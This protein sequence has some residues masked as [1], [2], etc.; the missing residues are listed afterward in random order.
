V[1][2]DGRHAELP[3]ASQVGRRV[4]ELEALQS[5]LTG[6]YAVDRI[7]GE[8]GMATVYLAEDIKH[9]RKVAIKVLRPE[10]SVALGSQRFQREIEIAA[11]LS[12]P[13]IHPLHDSGEAAGLLYYVMP[14]V[15][16][17]SL[18]DR[19]QRDKHLP[20][21]DALEIGCQ[22]AEALNYAHTEGVVHRDVKPENILL[23]RGHVL[24]TDFGIAR[25]A[26]AVGDAAPLTQTGLAVGTP[27]YMSP[28]Q[29]GGQR[30]VDA[31]CDV[32][33]L[34]CVLYE[35]LAG[36]PPFTGPTVESVLRQHL[37]LEAPPIT[38]LRP[39]V[40]SGIT[41]VLVRA[42]AKVPADRFPSAAAF[43]AAL[44]GAH[45][46]GSQRHAHGDKLMLAVGCA[47]GGLEA[48]N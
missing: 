14:Y 41:K 40:P 12:H 1:H 29:A 39:A 30:D 34:G 25:V 8:G 23:S 6:R 17:E 4:P 48:R 38:A 16:G 21:S 11:R 43:M 28:E 31:R 9:R 2:P 19:L 22:V 10:L 47:Y 35:M 24:V 26:H 46:P 27:A 7:V 5:A 44:R 37:V 15:E 32:Y 18:R 3:N 42:L 13:H 20:L 45:Q 36:Q 33:A